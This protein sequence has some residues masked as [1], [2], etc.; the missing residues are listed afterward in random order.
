MT[1]ETKSTKLLEVI[2]VSEK[3]KAEETVAEY[4]LS[5]IKNMQEQIKPGV[6]KS[7]KKK[8]K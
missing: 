7:E 6:F 3:S 4:Y 1:S 5:Q 2:E 8:S